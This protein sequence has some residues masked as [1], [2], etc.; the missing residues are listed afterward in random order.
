MPPGEEFSVVC[1]AGGGSPTITPTTE[2]WK[3]ISACK[4]FNVILPGPEQETKKVTKKKY[5][6]EV[7]GAVDEKKRNKKG[8]VEAVTWDDII[9]GIRKSL[10]LVPGEIFLVSCEAGEG[11]S[12]GGQPEKW[13]EIRACDKLQVSLPGAEKLQKRSIHG[14]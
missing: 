4:S 3:E 12:T 11:T 6:W 9:S 5:S 8:T 2:Q 1:E 10:G 13:A 14:R 7:T